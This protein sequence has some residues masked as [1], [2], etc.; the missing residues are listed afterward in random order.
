MTH[1]HVFGEDVRALFNTAGRRKGGRH[2]KKRSSL[3][4]TSAAASV[5]GLEKRTLFSV[6]YWD[7]SGATTANGGTG[8]WNTTTSEW[9]SGSPT[10]TLVAWSNS[11]DN[12]AYF[13]ASSGTVTLGTGV[14]AESLTFN[15]S[16]YSI[17][18]STLTLSGGSGQISVPS[19][20]TATISSA[21]AGSSGLT[22]VGAG[23]L[24]LSG[25]D[26]Y[27]GGTN[28]SA[29]QLNL[30]SNSAISTGTF[31]IGSGTTIDNT[32][33]STITLSGNN[34]QV[35]SG[36]FTYGGS[37]SLNLG[38]GG[39]TLNGTPT[40]TAVNKTLTVGGVISGTTGDGIT[41]AGYG[42]MVLNG[43][44]TFNGQTT[45]VNGDVQLGNTSALQNS[46][47]NMNNSGALL[48]SSGLGS[49]TVGS[50]S[51]SYTV[52]LEDT[53]ST[54]VALSVGNN[55]AT[56]S[57]SGVLSGPGS[58][59]VIGGTETLSGASN[60]SGGTTI[61]SGTLKLSSPGTLGITSG[62]L[63]LTGGTLD[64]DATNQT[65]GSLNGTGGTI[66]NN[67]SGT[68]ST[69]TVGGG[70]SAYAGVLANGS[71]T[72]ALTTSGTASVT[73]TGTNTYSGVTTIGS[74]TSIRI[75]TGG[76][77]GSLGTG[78]VTDNGTLAFNRS[79]SV[80]IANAISGSGTLAQL[81]SGI[82]T[83]SPANSYSGGTTVS[84]G[85]LVVTN[86]SGS[87]TGTGSVTVNSGATLGGTGTISGTVTVNSGAN[88]TPGINSGTGILNTGGLTLASGSHLNIILNGNVA[89][90]G[91]SQVD[92]SGSANVSGSV[93]ALSGT[94]SAEDGSVLTLVATTGSLSGTLSDVAQG[95]TISLN[96]V[97][98]TGSYSSGHSFTLTANGDT[99]STTLSSSA[100]PASLWQLVTFTATVTGSPSGTPTGT[101]TFKDGSVT[102]GSSN[103]SGGVATFNT[104]SLAV[105][106]NSITAV[107]MGDGTYPTSTSAPL[108][109]TIVA[110]SISGGSVADVGDTYTLT[111]NDAGTPGIV[112]WN[113]N[114]GDGT[115]GTI[116]DASTEYGT[117]TIYNHIFVGT[118]SYTVSASANTSSG[119]TYNTS[120]LA[121][122][123]GNA[124]TIN[125]FAVNSG[126]TAE[127]TQR[128]MVTSLVVNFD[129]PV[130]INTSAGAFTVT[131]TANTDGI[132]PSTFSYTLTGS[133][134][135]GGT[136]SQYTLTFPTYE[137]GSLP[138]GT[139]SLSV[140][141]ALVNDSNGLLMEHGQTFNFYRLFG[142]FDGNGTVNS[143]DESAFNNAVGTSPGNSNY[144]PYAIVDYGS[145]NTTI[146]TSSI[147]AFG[148]DVGVNLNPSVSIEP[149]SAGSLGTAVTINANSSTFGNNGDQISYEWIVKDA[150]GNVVMLPGSY[151]TGEPLPSGETQLTAQNSSGTFSIGP[152]ATTVPSL[153]FIPSGTSG[154]WTAQ[155]IATDLTLSGSTAT[156]IRSTSA[157]VNFTVSP[158]T[159]PNLLTVASSSSGGF[160]NINFSG[161]SQVVPLLN[162]YP[163]GGGN[164]SYFSVAGVDSNNVISNGYYTQSG[165]SDNYV[166]SGQSNFSSSVVITQQ[167]NEIDFTFSV[168]NLSSTSFGGFSF[169]LAS[170]L[171]NLN[172]PVHNVMP[173][174][175]S[176][177]STSIVDDGVTQGEITVGLQEQ[178]PGYIG[179]YTGSQGAPYL[180]DANFTT[181]AA[182]DGLYSGTGEPVDI[183][184]TEYSVP[185]GAGQTA[186]Y[187]AFLR[188][189]PVA[190]ATLAPD[191]D[192]ATST[193][194]FQQSNGTLVPGNESEI[195]DTDRRPIDMLFPFGGQAFYNQNGQNVT[196]GS[197]PNTDASLASDLLTYAAQ[198]ID[199]ELTEGVQGAITWDISDF[200]SVQ[201]YNGDPELATTLI[202]QLGESVASL[203]LQSDADI[204]K[205]YDPAC[206]GTLVG[207][208][209]AM[210]RKA[211]LKVGLTV[212]MDQEYPQEQIGTTWEG[213]SANAVD[214]LIGKIEYAEENW[215]CTLFYIDS[216][217]NNPQWS[218]V[219]A[220]VHA[221]VPNAL[222]IP[223]ESHTI[224]LADSG[225]YNYISGTAVPGVDGVL[226]PDEEVAYP[227]GFMISRT[228]QGTW[229]QSSLAVA[230]AAGDTFFV[231][232]G[233]SVIP[234]QQNLVFNNS[235][236]ISNY[237]NSTITV[238]RVTASNGTAYDQFTRNGLLI[239]SAPLTDVYSYDG[240]VLYAPSALSVSLA[241]SNNTFVVDFSGGN[242]IP[243]GLSFNGGSS[244]N[245]N[246]LEILGT[247]GNDTI[248]AG[249]GTVTINGATATFS[250]IGQLLVD[251]RG[252]SDTM[253]VTAGTVTIP[254]Q[255]PGDG[256]FVRNF[257]ALNI[258]SGA[259]LNV[260]TPVSHTDR[261]L[262]LVN[263]LSDAG[264]LDLGGNDMDVVGGSLSTIN[265]LVASG[266]NGLTWQGGSGITSAA[267]AANPLTALG[268]I[269]NNQDGTALFGSASLA[270]LFDGIAPSPSD[271]LIKYTYQGDAN[272]DGKVDGT[273]YGAID[274]GADTGLTGW[275]NG[276]FNYDGAI[277][278][279]DYTLI[280]NAYNLQ[281]G[282]L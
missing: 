100:N 208:Y 57:Y 33:T 82:T 205:Y 157:A 242:P 105:G 73:L 67:D 216:T 225:I 51:G 111:L 81:G 103:L 245:D 155:V 133:N 211:G 99:S 165:A 231:Q 152:V 70:T 125:S 110:P 59:Q 200:N 279:L 167:P 236:G 76:T 221:A 89:G 180:F 261:V 203:D 260:S 6:L 79:N 162:G 263:A 48:F 119:M 113:V 265:G 240:M 52:S 10:G 136:Y 267:A 223:E 186:T 214:L 16:G 4:H 92:V 104:S 137:G 46:T 38:T 201:Q 158:N 71:G 207:E 187:H 24:T 66:L 98:Y 195:T 258:S 182:L 275:R 188:F 154:T 85:T 69:L 219:L 280:D 123:V 148:A 138:N 34:P 19:G 253:S 106:S 238:S 270:T 169:T 14:T 112:Y 94:R 248:S 23:T 168:T 170:Y 11:A 233:S 166:A 37:Y 5:E 212:R 78:S 63:T 199:N 41:K 30:N 274:N 55:G 191:L 118:G 31:T 246:N 3:L 224:D 241:G 90:T 131:Q 58:L 134:G 196:I 185:L 194:A 120:T 65:V 243:Y 17:A 257:A 62:S 254:A 256:I 271:I 197:T 87:A 250:N 259:A 266:S 64:L 50:L 26:T 140:N 86:T 198:E 178:T 60:Y 269:Q 172:Y 7:P 255:A 145:G 126:S 75:G 159:T 147:E 206:A 151:G 209:F 91:Y 115:Y 15:A 190:G 12:D 56:S 226:T 220:A 251:P 88:L 229:N 13:P 218:S 278:S 249:A 83:L 29:G 160:Y 210:F 273:D 149:I 276:D 95:G 53:G 124:P 244:A 130:K 222:L 176:Q 39:V 25:T 121:V 184:D 47:V 146:D 235:S 177:E 8:T 54:A 228:D 239:Y 202:P 192:Q 42:N 281:G 28:L 175:S 237:S 171:Q 189:S 153:T 161:A 27:T 129:E 18:G 262:L 43:A 135:S 247:S 264:T 213:L 9:R 173:D 109:E 44:N 116:Q 35:W 93:L 122:S 204:A 183:P 77:T 234:V 143:A 36:S 45:I 156:P 22:K 282:Q 2:A 132:S 117:T 114:W 101:V 97:V 61:S 72:L 142:D 40:V 252:G 163:G 49:A 193:Q 80:L 32:S 20:D 1:Q 74:G 268:V 174:D 179:F 128:S 144:L 230:V 96:S 141:P 227:N 127:T 108:S 217:S 164:S 272:L 21:L 277:N 107:Y 232:N 215:G 84:A 139:Y 150:N 68:S 102:L 181:S